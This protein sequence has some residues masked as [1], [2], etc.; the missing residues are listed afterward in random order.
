MLFSDLPP[1][2]QLTIILN[3]KSILLLRDHV[4]NT[5][6]HYSAANAMKI[7]V[8]LSRWDFPETSHMLPTLP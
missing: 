8:T 2:L 1:L 7:L 5:L 3:V 6:R 4:R